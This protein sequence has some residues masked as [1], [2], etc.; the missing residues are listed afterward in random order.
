MLHTT[1]LILFGLLWA[2]SLAALLLSS[3]MLAAHERYRLL[4]NFAH[5]IKGRVFL[6]FPGIL[7]ETVQ[8]LE[9]LLLGKGFSVYRYNPF[10]PFPDPVDSVAVAIEE[11][12]YIIILLS[13]QGDWVVAEEKYA[14]LLGK[15]IIRLKISEKTP[16]VVSSARLLWAK[17]FR[18]RHRTTHRAGAISE[19][20]SWGGVKNDYDLSVSPG[21]EVGIDQWE[22]DQEHNAQRMARILATAVGLSLV[23]G[24]GL[25]LILILLGNS[26]FLVAYLGAVALVVVFAGWSALVDPFVAALFVVINFFRFRM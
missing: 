5:V 8:E 18:K 16:P 23:A 17:L 11:A 24:L 21:W 22:W 3:H 6:A 10:A 7:V 12:E 19:A 13:A 2:L 15:P 20:F 26:F 9:R 4:H 1:A 14:N 25:A